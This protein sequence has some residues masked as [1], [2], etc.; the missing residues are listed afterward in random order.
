MM[1]SAFFAAIG[2]PIDLSAQMSGAIAPPG[3]SS[4]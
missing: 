2:D 3:P 4:D 1:R